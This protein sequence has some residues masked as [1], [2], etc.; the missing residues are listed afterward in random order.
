MKRIAGGIIAAGVGS[1]LVNQNVLTP[2]AMIPIGGIPL[3]GRELI[4]FANVGIQTVT[5]I[6][7]EQNAGVCSQYVKEAFPL[8]AINIL[9]K[10]TASSFES[11][12]E[13]LAGTQGTHLLITTVDSIYQPGR[14]WAFI[15]HAGEIPD[16]S[17]ALGVSD[18]IDDEKPLYISVDDKNRVTALGGNTGSRVTCGVYF[19]PAAFARYGTGASFSSLR[20][21]LCHLLDLGIEAYG[22]PMGKVIDVD[23]QEDVQAAREW[24]ETFRP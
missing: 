2:K 16:M 6:F 8:L 11:F 19:L 4:E 23:R 22:F 21:F 18:Y 17:M 10:N 12:Y 7:N 1:R 20:V 9:C 24:T 14:L 13:I 5:V 15:K 3:I